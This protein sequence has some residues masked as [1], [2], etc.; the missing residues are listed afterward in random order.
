MVWSRW[1]GSANRSSMSSSSTFTITSCAR[2]ATGRLASGFA[3]SFAPRAQEAA[4]HAYDHRQIG[5][6]YLYTTPQVMLEELLSQPI[7]QGDIF[8]GANTIILMGR[9]RENGRMGRALAITKHRGS[10]H[11]E[12]IRPYRITE[13]GL[14]FD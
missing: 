7:G 6:L 4:Q 11:G 1:N 12:E 2:R 5:C 13:T 9:T 14:V 8:S 3:S 10:A